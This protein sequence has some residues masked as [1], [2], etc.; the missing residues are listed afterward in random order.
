MCLLVEHNFGALQ[1]ESTACEV[2]IQIKVEGVHWQIPNVQTKLWASFSFNL[3]RPWTALSWES[4]K[5]VETTWT[6]SSIHDVWHWEPCWHVVVHGRSLNT[7]L[8]LRIRLLWGE[9]WLLLL[10]SVLLVLSRRITSWLLTLVLKLL[11]RWLSLSCHLLL[12]E[13]WI[14]LLGSHTLILLLLHRRITSL[15]LS[16]G[17]LRHHLA[18]CHV[19]LG[20]SRCWL[21]WLLQISVHNI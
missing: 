18:W 10:L 7:C 3:R 9:S 2:F 20:T 19:L 15:L 8:H 11:M 21:L 17:C 14:H 13:H 5:K 6:H 4:T 12:H 1:F 16:V